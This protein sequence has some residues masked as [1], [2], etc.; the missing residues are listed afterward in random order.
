[1]KK[2]SLFKQRMQGGFQLNLISLDSEPSIAAEEKP[3]MAGEEVKEM[4]NQV[5][6]IVEGGGDMKESVDGV[7]EVKKAKEKGLKTVEKG[8]EF[9]GVSEANELAMGQLGGETLSSFVRNSEMNYSEA[10]KRAVR[11]QASRLR[12][13]V[14][15]SAAGGASFEAMKAR[16]VEGLGGRSRAALARLLV[17]AEGRMVGT[18]EFG[19]EEDLPEAAVKFEDL[20]EWLC[21]QNKAQSEFAWGRLAL[22]ARKGAVGPRFDRFDFV[23]VL[24]EFRVFHLADF[25]LQRKLTPPVL[26]DILE[27]LTFYLSLF[28]DADL[29]CKAANPQLYKQ[30]L[31]LLHG[32]KDQKTEPDKEARGETDGKEDPKD[33]L[34]G[35]KRTG[36][37]VVLELNM[38]R[39]LEQVSSAGR[40]TEAEDQLKRRFFSFA[41]RLELLGLRVFRTEGGAEQATLDPWEW[42]DEETS[43]Q[44]RWERIRSRLKLLGSLGSLATPEI[45]RVFA[46]SPGSGAEL[47]ELKAAA[48]FDRLTRAPGEWK[49]KHLDSLLDALRGDGPSTRTGLQ[50]EVWRHLGRG[51]SCFVAFKAVVDSVAPDREEFIRRLA[52]PRM[53]DAFVLHELAKFLRFLARHEIA[54][55]PVRYA[56]FLLDCLAESPKLLAEARLLAGA[57]PGFFDQL[58]ERYLFDSYCHPVFS[59]ALL[60]LISP[61]LPDELLVKLVEEVFEPFLSVFESLPAFSASDCSSVEKIEPLRDSRAVFLRLRN[62]VHS[63]DSLLFQVISSLL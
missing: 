56:G 41:R 15:G 7:V 51:P 60:T 44:G 50:A 10:E 40:G 39:L 19:S 47:L 9:G 29:F 31:E 58:V 17:L 37:K 61:S 24:R 57:R 62:R 3:A 5:D 45:A 6:K 48:A 25:A 33:P 54:G 13:S 38:A 35:E 27:V 59:R 22:I 36:V 1:M 63:K 52:D 34:E 20:F 42:P 53:K 21:S 14:G 32:K 46:V 23:E 30:L 11:A 16:V 2:P 26:L 18:D 49:L 4:R 43:L 12:D 28:A 55:L 8:F